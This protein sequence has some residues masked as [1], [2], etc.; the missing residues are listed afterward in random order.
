[1]MDNKE[2]SQT[3]KATNTKGKMHQKVRDWNTKVDNDIDEK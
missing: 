3:E 2:N 1:M